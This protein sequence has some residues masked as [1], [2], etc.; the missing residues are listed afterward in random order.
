MDSPIEQAKMLM[1]QNRYDEA[2]EILADLTFRGNITA[3]K[4]LAMNHFYGK[5]LEQDRETAYVIVNSAIERTQSIILSELLC[6]LRIADFDRVQAELNDKEKKE[7][8]EETFNTLIILSYSDCQNPKIFYYLGNFYESGTGTQIDLN[9]AQASYEKAAQ[10]SYQD[11]QKYQN[12]FYESTFRLARL[13]LNSEAKL[14]EGITNITNFADNF[15][16]MQILAGRRYYEGKLIPKDESKAFKYFTNTAKVGIYEGQFYLAEMYEK[17]ISNVCEKDTNKAIELYFSVA[18]S[19]VNRGKLVLESLPPN[20]TIPENCVPIEQKSIERLKILRPQ[21]LEVLD[22][23]K[24]LCSND[25]CTRSFTKE[26]LT[27]QHTYD[28]INFPGLVYGNSICNRCMNKCF[29]GC[30]AVDDGIMQSYCDCKCY[31]NK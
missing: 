25:I 14:Q 3:T 7:F 15:I 6:E 1:S 27:Y 23:Y 26:E 10:M 21:L 2:N 9:S 13:Q 18:M 31:H 16:K 24:K 17:G 20:A 22:K 19:L 12:I 11:Q 5:G 28:V 29:D 8:F 4:L 30:T